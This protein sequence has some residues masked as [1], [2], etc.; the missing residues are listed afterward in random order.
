MELEE[1]EKQQRLALMCKKDR[2]KVLDDERIQLEHE[3]QK[4]DHLLA[5]GTT[6]VNP[7][8]L[9][10]RTSRGANAIVAAKQR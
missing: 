4:T 3:Q 2:E 7:A 1:Q 5:L 9:I 8:K 6:Y 10:M